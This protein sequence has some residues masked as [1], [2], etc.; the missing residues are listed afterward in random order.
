MSVENKSDCIY[1]IGHGHIDPTWLWRWTEGYEEVRATFRSALDRME[2]TEAFVF[3]A[4]SACFYQWI[5]ECDAELFDSIRKRVKEGRWEIVGGLW[6]EPD[7]NI[8]LGESFVRHALYSQRFFMREFGRKA[9][10][11]FNP[12]S[13]GH[14]GTL[15]QILKKAGMDYYV[16]MRPDPVTEMRYPDGTVFWW[17]AQDGSRLLTSIIPLDYVADKG[18]REKILRLQKYPYKSKEQKHIL[19]FYGVGNHGGG[20]TKECIREIQSIQQEAD[21]TSS[22]KFARMDTFFEAFL[23]DMKEN[24]IP[25]IKTELQHHARGCYSVHS[26]IKRMNRRAEHVLMSAERF[27]T[28]AWLMGFHPYPRD[29]LK[30]A[31]RMCFITSFMT[32]LPEQVWK[33]LMRIQEINWVLQDTVRMSSQIKPYKL[34]Q[35]ILTPLLKGIRL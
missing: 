7:C 14:A 6:V 23:E 17:E 10:V 12:D 30:S 5:K 19:C 29:V 25:E 24:S 35:A 27:A 1:A 9:T 33:L 4:S 22:V 31:G 20:P 34:L 21:N 2:E 16:Y 26:E 3:S 15:P 11:G 32:S 8:P 13:F 18:I 28:I